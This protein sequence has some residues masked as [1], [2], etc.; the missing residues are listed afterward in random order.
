MKRDFSKLGID[1]KK[2]LSLEYE[3]HLGVIAED[4]KRKK[5]KAKEVVKEETEYVVN[6]A[7]I[8]F[9]NENG[10]PL[11]NIPSRPVLNYTIRDSQKLVDKTIDK[12]INNVVKYGWDEYDIEN[13]LKI[14]CMRIEK[15]ARKMI[16]DNN[17]TF[18]ANAPSTIKRKGGNHPLFDTG[19]LA[20]SI[21]CRLKKVL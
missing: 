16:Y 13:E 6:N 3:I 2:E 9:F 4:N 5:D 15:I 12:V 10:S 19:Q 21:T 7:A 18:V 11:R 8:L 17:D 14:L 20:R 1:L